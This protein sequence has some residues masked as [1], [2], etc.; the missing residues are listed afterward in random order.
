[1][2]DA[3]RGEAATRGPAGAP[4]RCGAASWQTQRD[5][6]LTGADGFL[7]AFDHDTRRRNRASHLSQLVLRLGP[8][9]DLP[10]FR[11]LL[12]EA[13]RAN[14]ILRA[15]VVRPYGVLPPVYRTTKP[16]AAV[17]RV[18]VHPEPAAARDVAADGRPIPAVFFDRL[19][20]R[21]DLRRGELLCCDVVPYDAGRGGTDLALTWAH[22][23]LDGSGSERLVAWLERCHRGERRVDDLGPEEGAGLARA[24]GSAAP[25]GAARERGRLARAW[26]SA[27][28]ELA[29]R[30]PRSL[31]NG[32]TRERQALRVALRTFSEEDTRRVVARA[33]EKAGFLTPVLFHLA[34]AI[35]AHAA[36]HRV[37]GSDPRSFAVPVVANSR[38]KGAA[39]PV[40]I[41]RTHVS[42]LWFQVTPEETDDL[43]ALIERLKAQ[44]LARIKQGFLEQGAA[45][46]D[47]A[48]WAPAPLYAAMARRTLRGELASFFFAYTG[49]FLADTST[50]CGAEIVNGFHAPGVPASPG[51]GTI[52][53]VRRGRLNAA[54]VHQDGLLSAGERDAYEA[55]LA[56]D[57]TGLET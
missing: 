4:L 9:F 21:F 53:S 28:T 8:G 10:G 52:L 38:P 40:P 2:A 30:P 47:F 26:Q 11:A 6:P 42:M 49:E 13:A 14:P 56:A 22:L 36:M 54:H 34:A 55:R 41:F 1:M 48:R 25:P 39:G 16:A 20:D 12:A 57:L 5:V 33:T 46:M 3:A 27:M 43:G 17:P 32:P 19:N 51:S 24:P 23:L 50:F 7:R 15:P 35:R 18:V 31:A 37:R 44:R 29:A 45:A